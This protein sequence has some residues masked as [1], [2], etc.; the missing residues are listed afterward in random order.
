MDRIVKIEAVLEDEERVMSCFTIKN[1]PGTSADPDVDELTVT[2]EHKHNMITSLCSL[3]EVPAFKTEHPLINQTLVKV[4]DEI[5]MKNKCGQD[6]IISFSSTTTAGRVNSIE[7]SESSTSTLW[8]MDKDANQDSVITGESELQNSVTKRELGHGVVDKDSELTTDVQTD[9]PREEFPENSYVC[10]AIIVKT[11]STQLW[12]TIKTESDHVIIDGESELMITDVRTVLPQAEFVESPLVHQQHSTEECDRK[13]RK[14]A[15][16]LDHDKPGEKPFKCE[17][18]GKSFTIKF[19]LTQHSRIHTGEK[20]FKC[21][22]CG[23]SFTLKRGLSVHSRIHRSEKPFKCKI[24]GKSFTLKS[25]L[26]VHSRIHRSEKPFKCKV[27]GKSFTLKSG[28]TVHSQIHRSKKPFQHK[29]CGKSF[30][31]SRG[32]T[33]HTRIHTGEKPFKCEVCGKSFTYNIHLTEHS[34]SQVQISEKPSM[35][36][37][38]GKS[39]TQ[40][41][42]DTAHSPMHRNEKPF[43]CEVCGKSFTQK[44]G[45]TVHSR[46]NT[47]GKLFKCKQCGKSFTSSG[48]LTLHSRIHTFKCEV[49]GKS[50]TYN[51][52]LTEHS[53]SQIHICE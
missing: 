9:L 30:T 7:D 36:Y 20:P 23:K 29:Q 33:L 34:Y 32:L 52:P 16:G 37:I 22:V 8:L 39:F 18:C 38:C 40:K 31:S 51:F 15:R 17:I 6:D 44:R 5:T 35:C 53:Y 13:R 42:D 12:D 21:K 43:K 48:S 10:P 2:P 49:C 24:C 46:R 50:F 1:E 11:E 41:S 25:G 14:S 26:T 47:C 45:F 3:I 4:K 27:C 19:L 28:L